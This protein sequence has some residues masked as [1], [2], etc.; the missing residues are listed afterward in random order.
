MAQSRLRLTFASLGRSWH[1]VQSKLTSDL[2]FV[3][4]IDPAVNTDKYLPFLTVI[5]NKMGTHNMLFHTSA[6]RR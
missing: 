6:Y 3:I 4:L 2:A 5:I 1:N